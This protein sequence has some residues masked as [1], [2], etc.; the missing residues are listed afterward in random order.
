MSKMNVYKFVLPTGKIIF[1]KEMKIADTQLAAKMAGKKVTSGNNLE[2]GIAL[3]T[4]LIK[5]LL[6]QVD[7]KTLTHADKNN[8]DDL[9]TM[10]EFRF[11]NKALEKMQGDDSEGEEMEAEFVAL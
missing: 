5:L 2:M 3:Q 7:D 8:L 10:K 11:V 9:F 1:L 6:V 4:E